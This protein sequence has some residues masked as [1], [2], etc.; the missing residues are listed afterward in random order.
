MLVPL[1]HPIF[2]TSNMF[3]FKRSIVEMWK[4]ITPMSSA[5]R[6]SMTTPSRMRHVSSQ[7][8]WILR[9]IRLPRGLLRLSNGVSIPHGVSLWV[10]LVVLSD[11]VLVVVRFGHHHNKLLVRQMTS[12]LLLLRTHRIH[13]PHYPL[14]LHRHVLMHQPEG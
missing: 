10:H 11:R 5:L 8:S 9:K 4:S 1:Y 12:L 3:F 2:E 14:W 7:R 13:T 6:T